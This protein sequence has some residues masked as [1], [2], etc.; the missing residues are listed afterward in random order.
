MPAAIAAVSLLCRAYRLA[1]YLYPRDFRRQ[2]GQEMTLLFRD[3]CAALVHQPFA[4]AAVLAHT[5][6]DLAATVA[7]EHAAAFEGSY[8]LPDAPRL[9]NG[10]LVS[11][12]IYYS[13]G[14]VVAM[15]TPRNRYGNGA[16]RPLQR[17][18]RAEGRIAADILHQ[19]DR[20]D[21]VALGVRNDSLV[22][23]QRRDRIVR[24]PAFRREIHN[25]VVEWANP[26]YQK[27]IDRYVAGGDVEDADLARAWGTECEPCRAFL[28]Q[29]R[30]LN[31]R[32]HASEQVR[33]VAGGRVR[34]AAAD[35][36]AR[37]VLQNGE[38]AL[39]IYGA[40]HV[41]RGGSTPNL[42]SL[43][44]RNYPG[45]TY[46]VLSLKG[47]EPTALLRLRTNTAG[48]RAANSVVA[49]LALFAPETKLRDIADSA[50][51][52]GS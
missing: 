24:H 3:R 18:E 4:L 29:M 50:V 42:M 30:L 33:V 14:A 49:P 9:L 44:D 6:M 37:E 5:S 7:E 48:D 8:R 46:T 22:D 23:A 34:D 35:V 15:E 19:F 52:N 28:R 41:W 20:A 40:D 43:L 10:M 31:L 21:L 38:K 13:F 11:S 26:R 32:S 25:I 2:Y 45:R 1:L 51:Y 12:L 39:L 36:I 27:S 17:I 47:G 16:D